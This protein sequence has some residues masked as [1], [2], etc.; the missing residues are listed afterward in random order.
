MDGT[1][2]ALAERGSPTARTTACLRAPAPS[3]SPQVFSPGPA[4]YPNTRPNLVQLTGGELF[5]SIIA[6]GHYSEAGAR[7]LTITLLDAIK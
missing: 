5:D 6:K 2:P 1:N 3:D 4:P 7:T